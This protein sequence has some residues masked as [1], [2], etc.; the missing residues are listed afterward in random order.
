M[1]LHRQTILRP[2]HPHGHITIHDDV[3]SHTTSFIGIAHF[4][5]T[6]FICQEKKTLFPPQ[7]FL[8]DLLP[9]HCRIGPFCLVL[10]FS[11]KYFEKN[12]SLTFFNG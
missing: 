3:T 5:N 10:C 1:S 8:K 4:A 6:I 7:K 2:L 11:V 12:N 9:D